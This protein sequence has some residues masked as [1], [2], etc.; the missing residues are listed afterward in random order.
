MFLSY[1]F[2]VQNTHAQS[3]MMGYQNLAIN[4]WFH[5]NEAKVSLKQIEK[6]VELYLPESD[7]LVAQTLRNLSEL[8]K[9][10]IKFCISFPVRFFLLSVISDF[11][12]LTSFSQ[13]SE[14]YIRDRYIPTNRVSERKFPTDIKNEVIFSQKN[15]IHDLWLMVSTH[16]FMAFGNCVTTYLWHS[17]SKG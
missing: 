12:T 4:L 13:L 14:K 5:R 3:R 6:F 15:L 8:S 17:P 2:I 1:P 10:S 16:I 7:E 11:P 9:S